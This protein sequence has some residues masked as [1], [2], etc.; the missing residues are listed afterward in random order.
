MGRGQHA[1]R[2]AL[3]GAAAAIAAAA[4][5]AHADTVVREGAAQFVDARGGVVLWTEPVGQ[6][7]DH[8]LTARFIGGDIGALPV[9]A[10]GPIDA[11]LA[12]GGIDGPRV[13]FSRCS[14]LRRCDLF[15][16][17]LGTAGPVILRSLSSRKLLEA[18]PSQ[19]RGTYVFG[20]YGPREGQVGTSRQ[21]GGVFIAR[22]GRGA[23]RVSSRIPIATDVRGKVFAY[24]TWSANLLS[25]R[26]VVGSTTT[27]RRCTVATGRDGVLLTE[28][29]LDGRWIYW[30]RTRYASGRTT[31]E[32]TR[33]PGARCRRGAVQ[34][35]PH[36]M[37]AASG[38][39]EGGTDGLAVD[40]GRVFYS[41][42][43]VFRADAPPPF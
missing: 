32:R 36:P 43:G 13:V 4:A 34:V 27:G 19:W 21:G 33:V 35:S 5:P 1:T 30:L 14:A 16:Y 8:R 22:P 41:A 39:E 29:V 6:G 11:D 25:S 26:L 40:E 31:I 2:A 37:P 7:P 17:E 9:R 23:R 18:A 38:G 24:A 28:P 15:R 20:R 42:L 10:R 3:A 12:P